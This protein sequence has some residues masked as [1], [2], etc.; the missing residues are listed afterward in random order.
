MTDQNPELPEGWRKEWSLPKR[1]RKL[2]NQRKEFNKRLNAE[3]GE[4]LF[5]ENEQVIPKAEARLAGIKMRPMDAE[6]KAEI[7]ERVAAGETL[8][9]ILSAPEMPSRITVYKARDN[10]PEFASDMAA[11]RKVAADALAEEILEISDNAA[12][13]YRPDGSI[14]YEHIARS[15]LKTDTRRWLIERMNPD[16]W[17]SKGQIDVTSGGEKLEAKELNPLESARQVAF[18]IELARRS[19]SENET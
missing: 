18:A 9:K 3:K 15:K 5:I 12:E 14:N 2:D 6:L 13:D 10:D 4:G 8:T 7:V 19:N 1:L 11:A 16:S 17:G